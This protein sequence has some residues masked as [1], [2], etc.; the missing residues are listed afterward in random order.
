MV[1]R[2]SRSF[3]RLVVARC[4]VC[5]QPAVVYQRSTGK[6]LCI[7]HF[8]EH[9]LSK[10]E[11]ILRRARIQRSTRI[12]LA[13]S[14]G[15]D[16]ATLLD[17]MSKISR[18]HGLELFA[19]HIYLGLGEY[20]EKLLHVVKEHAAR[21]GVPL[22]VA[23]VRLFLKGDGIPEFAKKA[24]RP[25]CSVCGLVKR[26]VMNVVARE[27]GASYIATGHNAD[28]AIAYIFKSFMA[29]DMLQMA[30]WL[31]VTRPTSTAAGR[32]RPLYEVY[33]KETLLYAIV[34]GTPF[35]HEECP[36]RPRASIEDRIKELMNKLEEEHP[37][38][39]ISF[40]RRY[41]RNIDEPREEPKKCKICGMPS[42]GE[43]CGY[44]KL[45]MKVYGEPLGPKTVETIKKLIIESL[46]TTQ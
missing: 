38:L 32:L 6:T 34:T 9:V 18:R 19:L 29:Q 43:T 3:E 26:Y 33:E 30:K 2:R 11:S 7:R 45:T 5:G 17:A 44:C 13:V 40:L 41:V 35:L 14:G 42:A 20:S 8:Q 36:H 10:I 46:G 1:M 28:D 16:S 22:I 39:K 15:K 24:K 37:G 27:L 31:P 4:S 21:V 25:T 23:D 12:L